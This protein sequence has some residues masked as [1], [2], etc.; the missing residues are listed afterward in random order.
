VALCLQLSRPGGSLL[1]G[2]EGGDE[3]DGISAPAKDED[4]AGVCVWGGGADLY[5]TGGGQGVN[6]YRVCAECWHL[7]SVGEGV[8]EADGISVPAK[9]EHVAGGGRGLNPN[10]ESIV[11]MN[12]LAHW[13]PS[14]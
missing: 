7:L 3:A 13:P 1:T 2:G 10:C 12:S 14:S 4:I 9:D 8:D 5:T 6:L 11:C